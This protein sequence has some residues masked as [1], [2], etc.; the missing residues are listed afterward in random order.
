M[1]RIVL[2]CLIVLPLPA[3]A[4]LYRWVDP[5]TGSVKYSSYP[6]PWYGDDAQQRRAP[7]VERIPAGREAPPVRGD[8]DEPAGPAKPRTPA[9]PAG[10]TEPKGAATN[11]TEAMEEQWR[12]LLARLATLK[13]PED[14]ERFP[15]ALRPQMEAFGTLAAELDKLDPGGA[16]RRA[17][18]S[19]SV[20]SKV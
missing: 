14:V 15:G 16:E 1:R 4:D 20:L 7:K 3:A 13:R 18:E 9:V 17:A 5:A 8:V 2:A 19:K 12:D 10:G 11:R 6:P